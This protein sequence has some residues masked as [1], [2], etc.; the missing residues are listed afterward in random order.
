[1]PSHF[2]HGLNLLLHTNQHLLGEGL[3]LRH[4]CDWAVFA[5]GFSDEEFRELFEEKLKAV[6]CGG[7]PGP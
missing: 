4:L 2:H 3:G 1:M 5:A 6:D 7:L